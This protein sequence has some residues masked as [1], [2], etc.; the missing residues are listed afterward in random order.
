MNLL[1]LIALVLGSISM[2]G[3]AHAESIYTC[4]EEKS[5]TIGW[6]YGSTL[7]KS[8]M[9]A[10]ANDA[11]EPAILT[12][13]V[14]DKRAVLKGNSGQSL[15]KKISKNNFLE[16]SEVGNVFLWTV[17]P[18]ENNVPTYI[19]H[20]KAYKLAVPFSITVAYRCQ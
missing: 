7:S 20:Q 19:F 16:E 14:Q 15:L 12:F 13:I 11:K 9:K 2:P 10:E 18:A 3:T 5:V 6:E 1:N 4:K 8:A 17:F